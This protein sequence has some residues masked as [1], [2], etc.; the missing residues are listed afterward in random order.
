MLMI[1]ILIPLGLGEIKNSLK[2]SRI[3]NF[4]MTYFNCRCNVK[5]LNLRSHISKRKNVED[6]LI[7][8]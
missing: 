5:Y 6:N 7:K 2:R 1:T 3:W 4:K 8:N